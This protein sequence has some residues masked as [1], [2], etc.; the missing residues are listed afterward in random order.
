[1][2]GGGLYSQSAPT[3]TFRYDLTHALKNEEIT[4]AHYDLLEQKL[5]NSYPK[6]SI[7]SN[8]T[9]FS[10]VPNI[11]VLDAKTSGEMHM[12]KVVKLRI[13]LSVEDLDNHIAFKQFETT[14]LAT[15]ENLQKAI[16][17][18]IK[19]FKSSDPKLKIFFQEAEKSV[20]SFYQN[21]CSKLIK[22]AQSN[23]DRKEFNKAY[24]LLKYVPE[25]TTCY[26]EASRLLTRIYTNSKDENCQEMLHKARFEKAQTNYTE[27]IHHLSLIDPS[28]NCYSEA[29]KLLEEIGNANAEA[30]TNEQRMKQLEFEKK[31]ELEKIKI[32]ADQA[33]YLKMDSNTTN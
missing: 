1:M 4:M 27:A 24:A 3:I 26:H 10:I 16:S 25:N 9:P 8:Q 33:D 32:L 22:S 19:Q 5:K 7:F 31:T 20:M 12:V 15:D 21:N 29:V 11:V 17:K 6:K 18:A 28:A 30:A 2:V 23:I 13:A 14:V